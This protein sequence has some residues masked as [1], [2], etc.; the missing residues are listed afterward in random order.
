MKSAWNI[1]MVLV[2]M[3][4]ACVVGFFIGH[5]A[6]AP[7]AAVDSDAGGGDS[8]SATPTVRTATI[9][10]GR[11]DR[12][13]TAYGVVAAQSGDVSVLSV[14]FESRVKKIFVVVGERLNTESP[15]IEVEPSPDTQL[16]MLQAKSAAAAAK[17]DL[18]QTHRRFTDHL[19]TNQ[20][21]SQAQQ[22]LDLAQL[23]LDSLQKEGADG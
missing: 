11:I 12:K 18:E 8:V 10:Q 5:R 21:L 22:N 1:F 3:A 7:A 14:A 9:R 16:Q 20:D 17:L 4:G 19:A 13:I 6:G 23:K 15:V 2:L